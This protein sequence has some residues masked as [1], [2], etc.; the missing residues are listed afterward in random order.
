VLPRS[1]FVGALIPSALRVVVCL[2][3]VPPFGHTA[4]QVH[5]RRFVSRLIAWPPQLPHGAPDFVASTNLAIAHQG[6]QIP[7]LQIFIFNQL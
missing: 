4:S 3:P 7:G 6:R 1:A 5:R 2:Y